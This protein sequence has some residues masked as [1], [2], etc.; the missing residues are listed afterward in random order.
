LGGKSAVVTG[1]SRGIGRAIAMGLAAQGARVV[2][3]YHTNHDLAQ[4]VVDKIIADGGDAFAVG[5]DL[6]EEATVLTL[7]SSVR[8]LHSGSP[9]LEPGGRARPAHKVQPHTRYRVAP[10]TMRSFGAQSGL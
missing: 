7:W 1:A 4:L 2:V 9:T 6:A 5:G 8:E 10:T 3:G